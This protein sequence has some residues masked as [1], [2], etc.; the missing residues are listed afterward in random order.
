MHTHHRVRLTLLS[1]TAALAAAGCQGHGKHTSAFK[2]EAQNRMNSVKAATSWDMANQQFLAGEL[3]K[4]LKTVEESL[5]YNKKVSKSHVLKGRI[6]IEMAR[7]DAALAS[8]DQALSIDPRCTDAHYFR[9][10]VHERFNQF[11]EAMVCYQRAA[12]C[13]PSNPQYLVAA[14]ETLIDQ[15]KLDEARSLLQNSPY[16]FQHNAGVRQTLGHIATLSGNHAEATV[17][18]N[19]AA[20]LAPDD[21]SIAEDQARALFVTSH[22]AQAESALQRLFRLHDP[23]ARRDLLHLHARCFIQLHKPVE[24]R[25]ILT[26]LLKDTSAPADPAILADLGN[27]ALTLK[28]GVRLREAGQRLI[29]VAPNRPE[30]YMFLAVWQR[31]SGKPE[32]AV[33]TLDRVIALTPNDTTPMLLRAMILSDLGRRDEARSTLDRALA[34]NPNHPEARRLLTSLSNSSQPARNLAG[35]AVDE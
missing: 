22:Y 27:V 30:G 6:L 11:E 19:E 31:G 5:T 23:A 34:I 20:L 9:G 14:A 2:E 26:A 4:A 1:L 13:D 32:Q 10:I 25:H 35:A 18:F 3:D 21:A 17:F 12:E 7:L 15:N 29:A 33:K 16:A 8:F 24:A 28:D